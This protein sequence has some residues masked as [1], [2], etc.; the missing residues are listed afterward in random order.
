MGTLCLLFKS[1]FVQAGAL[2]AGSVG[3]LYELNQRIYDVLD[4]RVHYVLAQ[5]VHY[6]LSQ[7]VQHVVTKW[8]IYLHGITGYIVFWL[9]GH[10]MCECAYYVSTLWIDIRTAHRVLSVR[11]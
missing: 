2:C 11:E 10:V 4:Q 1:A 9:A 7:W 3:T 5:W 8:V 6:V